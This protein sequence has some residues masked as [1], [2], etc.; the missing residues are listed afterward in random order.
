MRRT[1]IICTIGPASNSKEMIYKLVESGMNVARLNFSHGSHEEHK[2]VIDYIK[3]VRK[4][5]NLPIGILLDTKGPEIRV[6]NI[7]PI[8]LKPKSVILIGKDVP[9]HPEFVVDEILEGTNIFFD[10]GYIHG[11]VIKKHDGFAEVQIQNHGV[12][13]KN[14]GVNI[15]DQIFDLPDL[16]EK[17]ISDI[18][19]GCRQ[20]IDMIAASFIRSAKQILAIKELIKKEKTPEVLVI[21]KIENKEGV[22]NFDDILQVADGIMC[23]RGDL[24]VEISITHLPPIQKKMIRDCNLKAKPVIIATQ[25]LESMIKNPMPTRAEASDVANAIYDAA[26]AVMLSGETAAGAYPI[27]AVKIMH[28]I[29]CEAEKDFDYKS[30]FQ[31]MMDNELKDVPS[32]VARAAV[33]TCY[34]INA[35]AIITCSSSGNSIRKICSYRPK[36]QIIAVTPSIKTYYQTSVYWGACAFLEQEI[37]IEKGFYDISVFSLK[38]K[39]VKYGDL[40]VVT[41]GKPYGI[42][43]TTNTLFVESIGKVLVRGKKS[44]FPMELVTAEVVVLYPGD[45]KDVSGKIVVT[46]KILEEDRKLIENAKGVILQNLSVDNKSEEILL[47]IYEKLKIPYIT[48]AESA[49]NLLKDFMKVRLE[50][51]LGLVFQGESPLESEMIN[52]YSR[53]NS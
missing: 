48:R 20:G 37:D 8:E 26:S 52:S 34:N 46:T 5:L 21:A 9:I 12:L 44:D 17:D 4:E 53:N 47:S 27:Q 49:M 41:M 2:K 11:R 3:E 23:A 10:D 33:N 43:S 13:K 19:F 45:V 28:E 35:S 14:K 7:E 18:E 25:M 51:N 29:I 39:W 42:S 30:F 36:A 40:V 22:K 32:G 38:N 6:G 16:T 50:A 24:G 31:K 1:K 15:P